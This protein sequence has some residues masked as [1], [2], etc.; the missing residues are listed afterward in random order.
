MRITLG[1]LRRI[2]REEV[3]REVKGT[4]PHDPNPESSDSFM[5]PDSPEEE[6]EEEG[7][8]GRLPQGYGRSSKG[9]GSPKST[10]N[11]DGSR[12]KPARPKH[13]PMRGR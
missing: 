3:M 9:E 5:G 12:N 8:D 1:T 13:I 11:P 7:W 2:I 6:W 10:Y 4:L